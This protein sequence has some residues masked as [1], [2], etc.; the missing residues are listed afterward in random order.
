MKKFLFI[1]C[2]VIVVTSCKKGTVKPQNVSLIGKWELRHYS[3]TIAGVIKDLPAGNGNL[4]QFNADS[5]YIHFANFTQDYQG[6]FKIIKNGI[7]WGSEK[8]DAIYFSVDNDPNYLII[9]ADS[10]TIGNINPDGVTSLYI[11]QK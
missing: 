11:K 3:G 4:L 6:R 10:L 2:L 7:D 8:H 5:T 9:K 1:I